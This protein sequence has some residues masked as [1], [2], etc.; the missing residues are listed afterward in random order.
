[1]MCRHQQRQERFP[2]PGVAADRQCA[3]RIAVVALPTRNHMP[4]L[5]LS[6][7]DKVLPRQLQ[8]SLDRLGAARDE[9]HMIQVA[10]RSGGKQARQILRRL[11]RKKRSVRVGQLPYLFLDRPD[12]PGVPMPQ[13]RNRGAA[14][15]INVAL[16]VAVYQ[17]HALTGHRGGQVNFWIAM[18]NM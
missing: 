10:R 8:C 18:K 15:S 9:I 11:R 17:F 14:G 2:A 4:A 1:M 5:G 6:N 3:Q 13:A 16:A 12:H 7:F